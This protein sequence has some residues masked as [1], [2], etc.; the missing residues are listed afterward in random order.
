MNIFQVTLRDKDNKVSAQNVVKSKMEKK[1]VL[2][3][4]TQR[5]PLFSVSV[6]KVEEVEELG[7]YPTPKQQDGNFSTPFYRE[8]INKNNKV[9]AEEFAEL[10][11]IDEQIK[12]IELKMKEKASRAYPNM[13]VRDVKLQDIASAVIDF[14]INLSGAKKDDEDTPSK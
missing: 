8:K 1:D 4:L 9:F 7:G 2:E 10:E 14:N 6:E 12:N 13:I 3:I 5:Y 11:K